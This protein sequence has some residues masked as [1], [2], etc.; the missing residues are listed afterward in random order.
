MHKFLLRMPRIAQYPH[1]GRNIQWPRSLPLSVCA[2]GWGGLRWVDLKQATLLNDD[3][4]DLILMLR[5]E[6]GCTD[7]CNIWLTIVNLWIND[8][9]KFIE[10]SGYTRISFFIIYINI[11]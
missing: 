2:W 1:K 5:Y 10:Y 7:G 8:I 6:D 3:V 4:L 11:I 9:P